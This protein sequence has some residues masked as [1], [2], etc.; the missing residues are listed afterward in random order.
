MQTKML[1]DDAIFE[2]AFAI[3]RT[4]NGL[5]VA[6]VEQ[7]LKCAAGAARNTTILDCGSSEYVRCEKGLALALHQND[8]AGISFDP[9]W[10]E[11]RTT[12]DK[13]EPSECLL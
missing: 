5:T 3:L 4:L 12:P 13:P 10:F 7:V 9:E 8:K 11:G 2:H 6:E 1:S